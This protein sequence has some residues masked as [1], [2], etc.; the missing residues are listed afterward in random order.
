M[1]N[2]RRLASSL[3][4][5]MVVVLIA[6]QWKIARAAAGISS[7]TPAVHAL[8]D[9]GSPERSPF[10]SDRYTVSDDAQNTGRRVNLPLPADCS[11]TPTDCEDIIQLV[12]ILDGFNPDPWLSIPFDG[13]L[14]VRTI[15]GNII[16]V[17]LG[18]TRM[19]AG[20]VDAAD[21]EGN[22][23]L[24]GSAVGEVIQINR[25]V[26]DPIKKTVHARPDVFLEEH[27]GFALV[28]TNRVHDSNGNPIAPSPEF[29]H[30]RLD[31]GQ[32]DDP[33]V[34]WYRRALLTAEWA[35][36]KSGVPSKDIVAVS[37]FS[38]RSLTYL[39][40]KLN[41][42]ILARPLP[43]VDLNI[44]PDGSRTVFPFD[45]IASITMN[46]QTRTAGV[47]TPTPL[48]LFGANFVPGA[49]GMF[50]FGRFDAPDYM[51][52]PGNYIP[53]IPTRTGTPA[54]QGTNLLHFALSTPSG[55]PPAKGW[56]VIIFAF[57]SN[58]NR[59]RAISELSI[60]QSHG[61]AVIVIEMP[62]SGQGPAGTL[63]IS[64]KDG[65][66]TTIPAPGR[67]F[68]Q[69][70][71]GLIDTQEGD[72]PFGARR[73]R[74]SDAAD[75]ISSDLL[76]LARAIQN[77]I[78]LDGDGKSDLDSSRMYF[79][80]QSAGSNGFSFFAS[81]EAI[82]A[83]VLLNAP[84]QVWDV[85]INNPAARGP[86]V[87]A[88]LAT[89]KPSLLNPA[90]G[91]TSFGEIAASV[92]I[93]NEN[94]PLRDRPVVV[95]PVPGSEAIQQWYDRARW[96]SVSGAPISYARPA[97]KA[98]LPGTTPRLVLFF[99][100]RGDQS[101]S[102][103]LSGEFIRAGDLK[104]RTVFYRHDMFV[105]AHPAAIKNPHNLWRF[106]G[107]PNNEIAAAIQEMA[108]RFF[109]SDGAI[110]SQTSPY[111]EAPMKSPVPEDGG[112]IR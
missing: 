97:R 68:D 95:D 50:A 80:G 83:A 39:R 88:E 35:A 13:D 37:E 52:Y 69:N 110:I 33:N 90:A 103:P 70:D 108:S 43:P 26:W 14:D 84:S 21:E 19:R 47:L 111:F 5:S 24:P 18:D 99:F 82:R 55:T 3:L 10:P 59:F 62:G 71:D 28:V 77:G 2:Y 104:D 107:E 53:S 16:L 23:I 73:L 12:N 74:V 25:I 11:A 4:A 56:P 40:E 36:R 89:R 101:V 79:L 48:S 85:L 91:L 112:Y 44:G 86:R 92:P 98:P 87:G 8:F 32:S 38:T 45:Q 17:S 60:P 94:I 72:H 64:M 57:G 27:T 109:E 81:T 78:D 15:K 1:M 100:A 63:T 66:S 96:V 31:L 20:N 49:V 7:Q 76:S 102:N 34:Q 61:F 51:V 67:G 65:R 75:Q 6:V 9:V 46:L 30:Y 93:Y 41:V 58:G 105:A 106:Q 29:E 42:D 54:K 22:P